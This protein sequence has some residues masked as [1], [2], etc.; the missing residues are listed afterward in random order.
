MCIC[1]IGGTL[2]GGYGVIQPLHVFKEG[3]QIESRQHIVRLH[4]QCLAIVIFSR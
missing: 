2:V 4:R 1:K 3:A